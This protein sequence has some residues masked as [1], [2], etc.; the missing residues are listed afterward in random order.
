MLFDMLE[1]GTWF[2]L[3]LFLLA[4]STFFACHFHVVSDQVDQQDHVVSPPAHWGI[5]LH[6]DVHPIGYYT[7]LHCVPIV[8]ANYPHIHSHLISGDVVVLGA[9]GLT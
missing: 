4:A 3:D 5:L 6:P 8:C 9:G 7:Q 2:Y 1:S